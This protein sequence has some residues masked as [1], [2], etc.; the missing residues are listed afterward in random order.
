MEKKRW[1]KKF[2][3][4]RD[5][6]KYNENL[7]LR[8]EFLLDL[9]W[10][11]NWDKELDEMN[12]NKVG[13]KY[14]YLESLIKLQ[15]VWHQWIDCRGI[16]GIMRK[17]CEFSKLP[18]ANHYS[19]VNRRINKLDVE[20][21]MPR[22][23]NVEVGCDGSG[24]KFEHSGEYRTKMYRKKKQ[25]IK[26]TATVDA[27]T[28]KLIDVDVIMEGKGLSE[29]EI[30]L[31]TLRRLVNNGYMI[32]KFF[33]DGSFDKIELFEFLEQHDIEP[34]IKI[35]K[36][37]VIGGNELRNRELANCKKKGY[38]KWAKQKRYGYRWPCTEGIF[39]A[40]KRKCGEHLRSHKL[41]NALNEAR[42]KFWAYE[43]MKEYA[44]NRT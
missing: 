26:V 13:A 6:V 5:W 14:E 8:G 32:K 29:P 30:A 19:T 35:R 42:R 28:R 1:G 44:E 38:K 7:V 17:L 23:K 33:G 34:V 10:V 43:N 9:D 18:Q 16:E 4:K 40:V 21:Q 25:Y 41:P 27:K 20:F 31:F 15:A 36:T 11:N 3:E 12:K 37:A 2:N 39:S 24:V 22:D